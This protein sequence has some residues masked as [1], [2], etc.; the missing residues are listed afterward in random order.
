MSPRFSR[1]P[2]DPEAPPR[3]RRYGWAPATVSSVLAEDRE[4]ER[5]VTEIVDALRDNGPMTR[6]EL[7]N[8]V[9]SRLWGPG[10][11]GDALWLAQ[12]RGA[13]RRTGGRLEAA[14]ID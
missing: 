2:P 7:R 13:V 14:E 1:R 3:P 12:R 8:A 4:V 9:E 11:F 10:R 5:E 6:R